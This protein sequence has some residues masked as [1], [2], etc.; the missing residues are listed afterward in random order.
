M[1]DSASG[2]KSDDFGGSVEF[3][4]NYQIQSSG[5]PS[6]DFGGSAS[7]TLGTITDTASGYRVTTLL[8]QQHL[9]LVIKYQ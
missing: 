6:D 2:F 7:D 4:I 8:E 5:S 9:K 3:G 1:I